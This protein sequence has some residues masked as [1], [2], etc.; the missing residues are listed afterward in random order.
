MFVFGVSGIINR[1]LQFLLLPLYT[2]NIG[3][4]ELGVFAILGIIYSVIPLVLQMG[5]GNALLRSWYDYKEEERPPLATTVFIFLM[6]IATPI[7]IILAFFADWISIKLFATEIYTR[8]LRLIC[9]LAFIDIFNVVPDTLMRIR[10][11]SVKYSISQ[12]VGFILQLCTIIYCVVFLQRGIEGIFIGMLVGSFVENALVSAITF[13]NFG[14]GWN[15]KELKK[16]LAFGTPLIFGR[17][18]SICFQGIDRFFLKKYADMRVVGLYEIGN[19]LSSPIAMLVS[20]PFGM[21]WPNMQFSAMK[22]ADAREYYARMLTYIVLAASILA[23][24]L[25]ICVEDILRIFASEKYLETASVVPWLALAAVL[26]TANPVLSLGVSLKRKSYLSP[27][28]VITSA[29]INI[30]L[31]FL[32]I[33]KWGMLGAAIAT[34]LSYIAMCIIRYRISELLVHIDYEWGRLIKIFVVG[35]LLFFLSKL[36]IIGNPIISFFV[37]LPIGL[38]LPFVLLIL[39]FYDQQE[40]NKA[41]QFWKRARAFGKAQTV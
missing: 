16:M 11:E 29:L 1:A 9:I 27:L 17:L 41:Q 5:L 39:G 26:D 21:I 25:A 2:R 13:R 20:T 12:T 40:R 7:L 8:H 30:G 10:N 14:L 3:P 35:L 22:D 19:K 18:A 37:H 23:L 31:N 32:L 4:R 15:Q 6:I 38:A 24:P 34:V 36:I 33:P 28:I